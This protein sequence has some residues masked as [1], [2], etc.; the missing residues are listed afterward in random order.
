MNDA[1]K[2]LKNR[3]FIVSGLLQ[4]QHILL[5]YQCLLAKLSFVNVTPLLRHHIKI[6]IFKGSLSFQRSL[7]CTPI[8]LLKDARYKD[9]TVNISLVVKFHLNESLFEFNSVCATSETKWT[10]W[11]INCWAKPLRKDIFKG[12]VENWEH[13]EGVNRWSC[14]NLNFNATKLC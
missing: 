6:L 4:K 9:L 8:P 5:P 12:T 13:L 14:K 11:T 3:C 1:Y 2:Q 7:L 10:Q